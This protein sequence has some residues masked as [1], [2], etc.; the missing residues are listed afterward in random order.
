MYNS[1][2]ILSNPENYMSVFAEMSAFFYMD[3]CSITFYNEFMPKMGF[4]QGSFPPGRLTMLLL[5]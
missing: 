5:T 3:T 1:A 2:Q 4:Q